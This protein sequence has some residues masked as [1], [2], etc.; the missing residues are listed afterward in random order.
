MKSNCPSCGES[1]IH[2]NTG[3][4]VIDVYCENCGWPDEWREENPICVI[5]HNP[6]VGICNGT[7]RCEDH[8]IE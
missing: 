2:T 3:A 1:L 5:C 8:W 4:V 7:W 6:G